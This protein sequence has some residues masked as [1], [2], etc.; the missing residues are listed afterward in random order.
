[1]VVVSSPAEGDS[2][3]GNLVHDRSPGPP[4][5]PRSSAAVVW[6]DL[7]CGSYRAD[8][9]LWLE[10]AR[11]HP[12]GAILDVGA[13][14]GRVAL[15]L[16][17]AGRRVIA[18][19]IDAELLAALGERAAGLDI[20]TVCAD[21][22]SFQLPASEPL[23]LCLAPMQTVQLLGGAEQRLAFLRRAYAHLRPGGLLALAL[24]TDVEPFDCTD[25]GPAPAPETAQI[26]GRSYSSQPTR[27]AL[28]RRT[29]T[30]ER[31]RRTS[32]SATV[33]HD[34]IELDRV[35][36]AEL[37][38]EGAAAG[39][40]PEPALHIPPTDEHAGSSVVMLRA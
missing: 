2:P 15:E 8:L 11:T 36:A 14:S 25:G 19:D 28:G 33:E 5:S 12:E 3:A 29:I 18:L 9:P 35:G 34:V 30:I 17:R 31:E 21:A 37:E 10:L 20:T 1:V 22:R 16:A 23:A 40:Q 4:S 13:G 32:E 38:R 26:D 7:E 39:L 6:H 24:V 27:L